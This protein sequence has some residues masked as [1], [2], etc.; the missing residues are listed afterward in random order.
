[1]VTSDK[2]EKFGLTSWDYY[3]VFIF[4]LPGCIS[5]FLFYRSYSD[6]GAGLAEFLDLYR[7]TPQQGPGEAKVWLNVRRRLWFIQFM[8]LLVG[9]FMLPATVLYVM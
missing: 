4:G 6:L 1:M 3:S 7:R 9:A 8:A 5:P 2:R